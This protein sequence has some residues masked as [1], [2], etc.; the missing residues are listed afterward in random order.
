MSAGAGAGADG[1]ARSSRRRRAGGFVILAVAAAL[2]LAGVWWWFG[3]L[4]AA[5]WGAGAG[6]AP[7][8]PDGQPPRT[9]GVRTED[10]RLVGRHKGQQQWE[11]RARRIEM[12]A[13]GQ[14]VSFSGVTDGVFYRAGAV[15]LRFEGE[16]GR[17][18]EPSGRLL[19][20]G[21]YTLTHPSGA[22]LESR[23]L[24]WEAG[25]QVLRAERPSTVRY[26]SAVLV[27]PRMEVDVAG[28]VVRLA[29][30]VTLD[31]PGSGGL[32]VRAEGAEYLPDSGEIRLLGPSQL[33][34][35]VRR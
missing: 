13:T 26:G 1:E 34:G 28:G 4:P 17:W 11:L 25:R 32:K 22:V 5:P 33:E 23:D 15:F 18:D 6:E 12:A 29:G 2:A 3:G 21:R 8:R 7:G 10:V 9:P 24:V 14:E 20:D 27:A 19:L 30:G 16:G 35:A 31:D